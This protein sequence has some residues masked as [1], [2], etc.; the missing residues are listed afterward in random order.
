MSLDEVF[1]HEAEAELCRRLLGDRAH[2]LERLVE[3][4]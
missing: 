4:P 2:G 3:S 1:T